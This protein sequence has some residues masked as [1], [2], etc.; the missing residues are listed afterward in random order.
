M[1]QWD[2]LFLLLFSEVLQK[3]Q[4]GLVGVKLLLRGGGAGEGLEGVN[5]AGARAAV[6]RLERRGVAVVAVRV[7]ATVAL[8]GDGRRGHRGRKLPDLTQRVGRVSGTKENAVERGTKALGEMGAM[9]YLA[10]P[11]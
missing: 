10:M 1:E 7:A 8:G 11:T 9:G 4:D 3:L 2:S 5:H 6:G